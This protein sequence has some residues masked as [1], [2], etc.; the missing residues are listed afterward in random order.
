MYKGVVITGRV[1]YFTMGLPVVTMIVLLG[2]GVS[3]PNAIDGIRLHMAT[4]R[5]ELLGDRYIW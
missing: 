1:V 2:R 5:G 4:W 3:L